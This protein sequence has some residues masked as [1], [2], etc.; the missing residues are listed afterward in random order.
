MY[1]VNYRDWRSR[2][3]TF[4]VGCVEF[5]VSVGDPCGNDLQAAKG[6]QWSLLASRE[7]RVEDL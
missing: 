5:R 3:E 2:E 1:D 4:G 7:T 6:Q